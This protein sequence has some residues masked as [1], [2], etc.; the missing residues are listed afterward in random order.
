MARHRS[1]RNLNVEDIYDDWLGEYSDDDGTDQNDEVLLESNLRKVKELIGAPPGITDKAIKDIL[2]DTY[3]DIDETIRRLSAK[4][5][6]PPDQKPKQSPTPQR[7]PAVDQTQSK[8]SR[9][10]IANGW[11][12]FSCDVM[13]ID[14]RECENGPISMV[15]KRET[16]D[17]LSTQSYFKKPTAASQS[18]LVPQDFWSWYDI[19]W[20]C[21]GKNELLPPKI[22]DGRL[23][24]TGLLG[25]ADTNNSRSTQSG[26]AQ[27]RAQLSS[28]RNLSSPRGDSSIHSNAINSSTTN[29]ST[30]TRR[31]LRSSTNDSSNR[32]QSLASLAQASIDRAGPRT[33]L[34]SL[35]AKRKAQGSSSVQSSLSQ[36]AET[37]ATTVAIGKSAFNSTNSPGLTHPK[38]K[39][40]SIGKPRIVRTDAG[41][42]KPSLLSLASGKSTSL[43]QSR[44]KLASTTPSTNFSES[45]R[46]S[47]QFHPEPTTPPAA[48]VQ[49]FPSAI[50][51]FSNPLIAPPSVFA[52]SLFGDLEDSQSQQ[53]GAL[54][55]DIFSLG[56]NGKAFAFNTP[57]PDD[58]LIE[59]REEGKTN[60]AAIKEAATLPK[61]PTVESLKP[62]KRINVI[63]DTPNL[64]DITIEAREE[65]KANA[66]AIK[67]AAALPK[68]PIVESLKPSKRINVIEEYRKRTAEKDSLNL[69]VVGHVDAGKSTLMGHLLYLL[70]EVKERTMRKYEHESQKLGKSSF[71]FA[72]VLD[73]TGEERSRGIT[74]DVAVTSFETERRRFTLLDVPGHRDFIP[75]MI[76]GAAQADVA[77]LV[78]DSTTGE[79]EAG[80]E[81]N[82][83]TKEHTLLVRS[84]GVQQLV[85]AINKLDMV[86][87]SEE[88]FKEI[89][90]KLSAFLSQAGFKKNKVTFVPC[91]G[92]TGENLLKK[93]PDIMTW[94]DG[95]TLVQQID[96]LEPPVRLLERPF[97]LGVADFFKGSS[98]GGGGISVAGRVDAG[99]IQVGETVMVIPGEQTGTVKAI[100]VNGESAKWAAAGDTI[101]TTL[102]GLDIINL[103][104]GSILCSPSSPVPVSSNFIAQIVVFDIKIPITK[105][106]P[107]IIH[108]QSLNEPAVITKLLATLDKSTGGIV[109]KNPR[110]LSKQTTAR[111]EI[112]LSDRSIPLETF[113]DNKELGRVMLRKAGE[114][115]AVGVVTEVLWR[116]D[117]SQGQCYNVRLT[118]FESIDSAD[119]DQTVQEDTGERVL[120]SNV[121]MWL[122]AVYS[123]L[124]K[125]HKNSRTKWCTVEKEEFEEEGEKGS[126][127]GILIMITAFFRVLC[128]KFRNKSLRNCRT[129]FKKE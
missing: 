82:G 109:K 22:P 49:P 11:Q 96:A 104:T 103:S 52:L 111:V 8:S 74:M 23:R 2:W 129:S 45:A 41:Q 98:G 40:T 83:Q 85:V 76:S 36:P 61:S 119:D 19:K 47:I 48:L 125:K 27:L 14:K 56:G 44:G 86:D 92:M 75:N 100:E 95:T 9:I 28:S 110:H 101:L 21:S 15:E 106:F 42:S 70:G 79:F 32:G 29:T 5:K 39:V 117:D 26:F 59:A 13:R 38:P 113:K 115:I 24:L 99:T 69:V 50:P 33:S 118:W 72:W 10:N 89:K 81:A 80:F 30:S 90:T 12:S 25:G 65:G 77:I 121:V 64:D 94:Y 71:A 18:I 60:A 88:R 17:L 7:K 84:L 66:A 126:I 67:E 43:V 55:I 1:I 51:A 6:K 78:V 46:E 91:S 54:T 73:E 123:S 105:G 20:S 53:C 93:S 58:E 124:H 128:K 112:K 57:S 120:C 114:T 116:G 62:S 63:E 37:S 97:R 102:T 108:H 107:V 4:I 127:I 87:W 35:I 16:L 3:Y 34:T 31:S 68:P 122:G